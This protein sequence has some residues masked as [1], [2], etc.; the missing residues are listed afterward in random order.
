[1]VV[2]VW[3]D[4]P[5]ATASIT[6]TTFTSSLKLIIGSLSFGECLRERDASEGLRQHR[7]AVRFHPADEAGLVRLGVE[8]GEP[9]DLHVQRV[10]YPVVAE[11]AQDAHILAGRERARRVLR[12]DV[13]HIEQ[14]V[15]LP[16]LQPGLPEVRAVAILQ[17]QNVLDP[18]AVEDPGRVLVI[19]RLQAVL[20][21]KEVV[22][23]DR[24]RAV[25]GADV[26]RGVDA[27]L[28]GDEH[29][30][31]L[32]GAAARHERLF[33]RYAE[34]KPETLHDE[35]FDIDNARPE[36]AVRYLDA[37]RQWV[38]EEVALAERHRRVFRAGRQF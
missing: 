31:R 32:S 35:P 19:L 28:I 11:I 25:A 29:A 36:Q 38:R 10:D 2:P 20:D 4:V 13:R 21:L 24:G 1:M 5:A 37:L 26:A 6:R 33:L 15:R 16:L 23:A 22:R 12:H 18:R 30:L 34:L 7:S 27:V 14:A 3:F 17:L 8:L 9:L